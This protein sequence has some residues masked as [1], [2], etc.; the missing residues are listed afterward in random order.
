M[1]YGDITQCH[2]FVYLE[3]G[4]LC[5]F[6]L[7][8]VLLIVCRVFRPVAGGRVMYD[9][10]RALCIRKETYQKQKLCKACTHVVVLV[11]DVV[12]AVDDGDRVD[13]L[14]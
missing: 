14:V 5:G 1:R 13:I 9:L 10:H 2:N 7:F 11:P 12:A 8:N 4:G 3:H 6:V